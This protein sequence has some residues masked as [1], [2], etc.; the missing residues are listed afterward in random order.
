MEAKISYVCSSAD[1]RIRGKG[2][3]NPPQQ[4][5]P[6]QSEYSLHTAGLSNAFLLLTFLG[7]KNAA[8]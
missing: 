1:A 6:L 5:L 8:V 2:G 3:E 7:M 4:P